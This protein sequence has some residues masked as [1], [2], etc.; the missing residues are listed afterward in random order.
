MTL[1]T[2]ANSI[3]PLQPHLTR[4]MA[5]RAMRANSGR[6]RG[7]FSG[8]VVVVV[9]PGLARRPGLCLA[10]M[11]RMTPTCWASRDVGAALLGHL[12]APMASVSV[13]QRHV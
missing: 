4:M 1:T 12:I 10:S 2:V 7:A 3:L 6:R 8:E 13:V 11:A 5:E 9:C